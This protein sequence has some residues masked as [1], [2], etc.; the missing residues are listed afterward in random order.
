MGPQVDLVSYQGTPCAGG[1]GLATTK[2]AF[3]YWFMENGMIRTWLELNSWSRLPRDHPHI[4]P[5]DAVVLDP[6][7][8]D[9]NYRYGMMHQDIAAR[10]LVIDGNDNLRI[11]DFNYSIMID[12]HYTPERDDLKGVIFTLYEIITLDEHF[13]DVPHDQQ[14]SEAV[15][16]MKWEKHPDVKL[17]AD[18]QE[19]RDVLDSWVTERKAKE[20]FKR[21][22]TWVRW[23]FV[24]K[25][26]AVAMPIYDHDRKVTGTK[27]HSIRCLPRKDLVAMGQ[28]LWKWERPASYNLAEALAKQKI[29]QEEAKTEGAELED[30]NGEID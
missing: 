20:F 9:L 21:A 28:E 11:F 23:P 4:V 26:P 2:A 22:D 1:T 6:H 24:P 5:F 16:K 7:V 27:M 15:L 12:K 13:R 29:P 25:P 10:N 18:V 8:D 30:A 14:D 17:D 3:K 19:S